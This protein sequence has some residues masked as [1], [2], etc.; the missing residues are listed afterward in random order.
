M[1]CLFTPDLKCLLFNSKFP[2]ILESISELYSC[3]FSTPE[4]RTGTV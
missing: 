3:P 4:A 2:Y 1:I